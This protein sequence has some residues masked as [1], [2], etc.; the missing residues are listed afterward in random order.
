[1]EKRQKPL[2]AGAMP[3]MLHE[4]ML[5]YSLVA[6]GSCGEVKYEGEV[7]KLDRMIPQIRD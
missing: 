6:A 4:F 2:A 5:L 3:P 1:M 7:A